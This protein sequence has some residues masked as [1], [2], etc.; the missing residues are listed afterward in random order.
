MPLI[1]EEHLKVVN[2][3]GTHIE[4]MTPQEIPA[5]VHQLLR[6]CKQYN[7]RSIF[8]RLQSYFGLRIYNNANLNSD[9]SESNTNDFD[10]IGMCF[11]FQF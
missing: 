10:A 7:G 1:K 11:F 5:F 3:L 9:S 4:K 6:L 8:L 2:K